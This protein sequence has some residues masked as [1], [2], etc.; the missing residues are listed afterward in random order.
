MTAAAHDEWV[1]GKTPAGTG[2]LE[3]GNA[4]LLRACNELDDI[5]DDHV[6]GTLC[7]YCESIFR[8]L[9]PVC[10]RFTISSKNTYLR[11]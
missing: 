6:L 2:G 5:A 4:G 8:A 1:I 7:D 10:C 9:L 11:S 3:A